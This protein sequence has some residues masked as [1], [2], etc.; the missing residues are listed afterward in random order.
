MKP[1]DNGLPYR[2]YV[3]YQ[4]VTMWV[5]EPYWPEEVVFELGSRSL[6]RLKLAIDQMWAALDTADSMAPGPVPIPSWLQAYYDAGVSARIDLDRIL[7]PVDLDGILSQAPVREEA[8]AVAMAGT[9]EKHDD[10]VEAAQ[11]IA[12]SVD[13]AAR[14][15]AQQNSQAVQTAMIMGASGFGGVI[16]AAAGPSTALT[17]AITVGTVTAPVAVPIA[18]VAAA[19]LGIYTYMRNRWVD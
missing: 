17:T 3:I 5:A 6:D 1:S 8:L 11:Q 12:I 4:D 7:G 9:D 2:S 14:A 19:T 18:L 16:A 13:L 10:E 15:R